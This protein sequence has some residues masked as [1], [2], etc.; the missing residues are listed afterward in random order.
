MTVRDLFFICINWDFD[1]KIIVNDFNSKIKGTFK[2][3]PES[4][5]KSK[6]CDFKVLDNGEILIF[7]NN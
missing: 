3:L 4:V 7:I 1:T 5:L 6:I 2:Q